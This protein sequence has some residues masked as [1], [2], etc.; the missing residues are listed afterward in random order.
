MHVCMHVHT[1]VNVYMRVSSYIYLYLSQ[2]ISINLSVLL[3][4]FIYTHIC[5]FIHTYDDMYKCLTRVSEN[6]PDSAEIFFL[7]LSEFE[8][9]EN[10]GPGP[11][12]TSRIFFSRQRIKDRLHWRDFAGDFALSLPV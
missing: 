11:T 7:S 4:V 2:Y 1:Y 10:L 6:K 5:I 12:K 9:E 3:S 8:W